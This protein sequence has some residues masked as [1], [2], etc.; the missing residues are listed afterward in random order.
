MVYFWVLQANNTVI[1]MEAKVY[2]QHD[3]VSWFGNYAYPVLTAPQVLS[4]MAF[5]SAGI[6]IAQIKH[7]VLKFSV[8]VKLVMLP[9]LEG[10]DAGLRVVKPVLG[11]ELLGT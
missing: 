6:P 4:I 2:L 10:Q 9:E 5:S 3:V 11:I 1:N 8:P 7:I